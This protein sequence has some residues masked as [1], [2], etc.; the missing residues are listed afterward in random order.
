MKKG[1]TV[2]T[3]DSGKG[4]KIIVILLMLFSPLI[5]EVL[6][7]YKINDIHFVSDNGFSIK[8]VD[9]YKNLIDFKQ[10]DHF[11][12][13]DVKKSMENL[14]KMDFFSDVEVRVEKLVENRLNVYFILTKRYTVYSIDIV[15]DIS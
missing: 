9:K 8:D 14:F 6:Q 5:G 10:G 11:S 13:K 1:I 3:L 2:L 12:Y 4:I 7:D 15:K